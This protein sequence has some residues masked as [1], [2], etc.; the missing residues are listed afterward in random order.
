M[1]RGHRSAP[2]GARVLGPRDQSVFRL[3][4]RVQLLL[5]V[6]LV[7]T[8]V[9]AAGVVFL[10]ASFVVPSPS[11]TG[12]TRLALAIAVPTYVGVAVLVGV[13]VGTRLSLRALGWAT[14]GDRPH[15]RERLAALRVP[16]RLTVMQATLWLAATVLFTTLS[17]VLQ[18]ERAL[19]T[20]L[21]VGIAGLVACGI[22]FLLTDFVMRPVS[23]QALDGL[24]YDDRP[25]GA[26]VGGRMVLFWCLGTGAPV[27]GMVVA[28]I[29]AAAGDD[30]SRSRL[31]YTVLAIGAVVL[32]F[33]LLTTVL[34]AR[35]VVAPVV[36]V[37]DALLDVERGDLD[38]EVVVFDGTELGSLQAGFNA[39]V[40]GL[41]EREHLRDLFG[42]HVGHD[43]ARAAADDGVALGGEVR[44]VSVLFVDL[45]GSTSYA[46]EHDPAEVVDTLNRFFGVVVEEVD[47]QRGL[48]NKFIGDAVLAV[49]GAPVDH[50]DHAAAALAAARTMADRLAAEVP[51]IGVGIGVAT[52]EA[53]AGNVGSAS[54]LEYT[55]IG[56]AVNSAARL[57]DLAKQVPGQVL[58]AAQTVEAAHP[59]ETAHW[60]AHEPVVLRGRTSPTETAI[61]TP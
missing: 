44:V 26:G 51:E 50:P 55:V 2:F 1:S 18:P 30:D 21:A 10:I 37:R 7:G 34:N 39:M 12:A 49:F 24:P 33:G 28:S 35:S 56:D 43:V 57:T 4:L 46:A 61:R 53:V 3:R 58:V 6:L 29:V 14:Q 45:V 27:V 47:R 52:G 54:R 5:T 60:R 9:I 17:L 48:V 38:R 41:R 31:P 42:R 11:P 13:T 36:S 16:Q 8:N 20:G 19:S 22:A 15:Q 23:A 40:S 25:R 32:V 59:D